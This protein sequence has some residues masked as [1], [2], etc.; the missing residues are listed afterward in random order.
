MS[1][2]DLNFVAQFLRDN[3]TQVCPLF[4]VNIY[5]MSVFTNA[6]STFI[7]NNTFTYTIF[8]V[9]LVAP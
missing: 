6:W 8:C 5:R 9:N 7:Q 1:Q 3:F 2:Q 4:Y